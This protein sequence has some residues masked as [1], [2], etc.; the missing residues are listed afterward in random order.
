LNFDRRCSDERK[1]DI[2]ELEQQE[3]ELLPYREALSVV[4]PASE[5]S[6]VIEPE[7]P[8]H[9]APIEEPDES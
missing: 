9:D 4:Q 1:L 5:V 2:E 3:G 8:E 6:P 7:H